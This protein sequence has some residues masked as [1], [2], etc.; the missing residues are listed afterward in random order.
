MHM[1]GDTIPGFG[2]TVTNV[3]LPGAWEIALPNGTYTVELSV[4][5]ASPGADTTS[6]EINVEGVKAIDNYGVTST[7]TGASAR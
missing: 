7:T 2:N 1:Q 3:A 6:H 5:D 4:G